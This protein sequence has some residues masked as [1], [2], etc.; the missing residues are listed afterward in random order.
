M[1]LPD[2]EPITVTR[3]D[4]RLY[5]APIDEPVR[6]SFGVMHDRPALV[7]RVEDE[8]GGVGWGEVWCNY[9]TFA[10]E[11]RARC[12]DSLLA[13]LLVGKR[14]PSPAD[15]YAH[16]EASTR[17]LALQCGEPGPIAQA[18]AG[19]DIALWDLA[20][21]SAGMPLWRLLGGSGDGRLPA[22]ASGIGPAD[23]VGMAEGAHRAGYRAF[24]LKVGFDSDRDTVNLRT[25][26]ERLGPDCAI[27]ADA[28]QR[29]GLEDALAR[30]AEL[31]SFDLVWLEEPLAADAPISD[32]K[33]LAERSPI[34]LAAGEN[35][36]GD[37]VFDAAI[38]SGAL[39]VI[40]PDVAK[41][42][43]ITRVLPL[44][45][46][47]VGAGRRYCPHFLGGGIGLLASAHLLA[48]AGGDGLLEVD[49]N[50][51]P[52]R[53][54]LAEPFPPLDGGRFVLGDAPGL[55]VE[56]GAGMERFRVL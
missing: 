38:G 18:I 14:W 9:P 8:G 54:G 51:N 41:W 3:I 52:L 25:L 1:N 50:P 26:H 13:P 27:A 15:A 40:Q 45:Q 36:R 11:H 5:R 16:L 20:A 56:P 48:A 33:R 30:S 28:N 31:A 7:V 55:G 2:T 24:K 46:R 35:M 6:S 39:R 17:I 12:V 32:W 42:G 43:G 23:A 34:P 37:A 21:R 29:W 53:E 47:I 44:A 10:A 49:C 19:V 22:Y 4:A